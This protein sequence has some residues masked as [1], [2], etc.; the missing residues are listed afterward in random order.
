MSGIFISYRREDTAPWAGRIYERL[1]QDFPR[2]HILMDVDNI[3]PG[4]DFM[5]ELERSV[6][7]CDT[8]ISVIGRGWVDTRN[9]QGNR[10]LDDPNDFVRIELE[11][12]LQRGVRVIP[13]LVDGATMPN[14]AE[15]PE[16]LQTLARRNAVELTHARFGSDVQRLVG[17]L[18]P[19][20]ARDNRRKTAPK[21][22]DENDLHFHDGSFRTAVPVL[23]VTM[24]LCALYILTASGYL[25]AVFPAA[26][27]ILTA[28][29]WYSWYRLRKPRDE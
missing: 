7:Q 17:A 20:A 19:V 29:L 11:A 12:A 22:K 8:L 2:D 10:R 14:A 18:T 28:L 3:A 15:L 13:V 23:L 4:L 16:P 24:V 9:A 25:A 6:G 21:P 26:F 5:K 27:T 1:V